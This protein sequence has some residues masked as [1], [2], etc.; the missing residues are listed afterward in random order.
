MSVIYIGGAHPLPQHFLAV[1]VAAGAATRHLQGNVADLLRE[2]LG[3]GPG[4]TV[5]ILFDAVSASGWPDPAVLQA[6]TASIRRERQRPRLIGVI[7]G[8]LAGTTARVDVTS[9]LFRAGVDD[10][11]PAWT[12]QQE[13]AAR[14][15]R[16]LTGQNRPLTAG[17]V[18]DPDVGLDA[19]ATR[20]LPPPA[21][22]QVIAPVT[23]VTDPP[24]GASAA[25]AALADITPRQT[26]RP[27]IDPRRRELTGHRGR[28]PLTAKESVVMGMLIETSGVVLRQQLA[29]AVWTQG[30]TGT[31]KAID[32]HVA[33]LRKKLRT[34]AGTSWRITT[35]RGTGFMLEADEPAL[36][37]S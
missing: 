5:A 32:M 14:L 27:S 13:V 17:T 23:L 8:R 20:A 31:P 15:G 28:I 7:D 16:F 2:Y 4:P 24:V 10:V 11:I 29:A 22:S 33:N 18:L 21:P 34:V 3:R 6:L 37:P 35:V 19:A 12:P 25:Q 9:A 30:W 26:P 36:T 1:L